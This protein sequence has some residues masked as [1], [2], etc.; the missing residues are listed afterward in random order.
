VLSQGNSSI[1]SG[2]L[3]NSQGTFNKLNHPN[4]AF[5]LKTG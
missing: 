5:I 1:S 4:S 3:K 2:W